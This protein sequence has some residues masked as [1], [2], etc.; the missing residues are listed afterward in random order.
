MSKSQLRGVVNR[1]KELGAVK[2]HAEAS[3]SGDEGFI[4]C[5]Q[6]FNANGFE[7]DDDRELLYLVDY[8]FDNH[9]YDYYNGDGGKVTLEIDLQAKKAKWTDEAYVTELAP[10]GEE[11]IDL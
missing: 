4:D 10:D 5:V 6:A 7:I 11:E 9:G 8:A 3:G 2:L 1:L